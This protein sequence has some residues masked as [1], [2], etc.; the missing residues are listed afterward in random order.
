[1]RSYETYEKI[2]QPSVSFPFHTK[3]AQNN[4]SYQRKRECKERESNVLFFSSFSGVE[5]I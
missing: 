1:M 4:L 5:Q 3:V 2:M